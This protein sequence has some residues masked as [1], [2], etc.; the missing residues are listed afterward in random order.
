MT[1]PAAPNKAN[2][3]GYCGG[4]SLGGEKCRLILNLGDLL[5]VISA[6]TDNFIVDRSDCRY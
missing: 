2:C 5:H 4:V 3:G 6:D 1:E